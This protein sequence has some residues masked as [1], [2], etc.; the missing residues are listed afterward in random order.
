MCQYVC[1][2]VKVHGNNFSKFPAG[3]IRLIKFTIPYYPHHRYSIVISY[4][5]VW[6]GTS[7]F[8]NLTPHPH[9][10]PDLRFVLVTFSWVKVLFFLVT[11]YPGTIIVD[12]LYF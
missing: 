12:W 10:T 9:P 7:T 2:S 5:S 8:F 6:Q 1:A 3:L 11:F 4:L